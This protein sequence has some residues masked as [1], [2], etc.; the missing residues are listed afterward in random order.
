MLSVGRGFLGPVTK[1]STALALGTLTPPLS[2]LS[3]QQHMLEIGQVPWNN[4]EN[5]F[6]HNA[7][8]KTSILNILKCYKEKINKQ[9]KKKKKKKRRKKKKKK[10]RKKRKKKKKRKK[11]KKKA[12]PCCSPTHLEAQLQYHHQH[13]NLRCHYH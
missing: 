5:C 3:P 8:S 11:R 4:Q 7:F 12:G 1:C 10:R 2:V 9:A 13:H 6:F